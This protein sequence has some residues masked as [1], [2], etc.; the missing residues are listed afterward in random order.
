MET[1]FIP[2]FGYCSYDSFCY[3]DRLE[4]N[5]EKRRKCWLPAFS[6]FPT[7]FSKGYSLGAVKTQNFMAKSLTQINCYRMAC[8]CAPDL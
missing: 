1:I 4:N 5:V 6:S 8:N 7:M 3:N 2:K